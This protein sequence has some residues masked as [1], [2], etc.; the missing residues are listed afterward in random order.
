[1]FFSLFIT[2]DTLEWALE[3][4]T[5]ATRCT[6]GGWIPTD[7]STPRYQLRTPTQRGMDKLFLKWNKDISN[8]PYFGILL[9][10]LRLDNLKRSTIQCRDIKSLVVKKKITALRWSVRSLHTSPSR[11]IIALS[12]APSWRVGKAI[13]NSSVCMGIR[14]QI[15]FSNIEFLRYLWIATLKY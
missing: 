4:L 9:S 15:T 8:L 6:F 3:W 2:S 11:R 7:S 14:W 1:M 12:S 10:T 5:V 13:R